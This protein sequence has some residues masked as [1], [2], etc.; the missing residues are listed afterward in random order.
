MFDSE[1]IKEAVINAI[2]HNDY[3]YGGSPII[4]LY[5]DR[6]EITSAGGLPVELSEED[7]LKGVVYRRNKELIKVFKD[8]DLIENVGSGIL[9]I[10]NSYDKSCFQFLDHYLR[11]SFKYRENPYEYED[12][13]KTKSSKK[14]SKKSSK[15]KVTEEEILE[16]CKTEKSLKEITQ[17]FG[18]KDLYKFKTNYI[19]YLINE[20]KLRMTIPNSPRNKNQK[21]ITK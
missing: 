21:Y 14:G 6:I 7:F 4:E 17:Y 2:C 20:N 9:R 15:L 18:Y 11:V 5:S 19:N 8:V 13:A 3:S 16:F 10:L 12:T 1:A